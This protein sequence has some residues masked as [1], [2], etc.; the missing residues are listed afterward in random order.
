MNDAGKTFH[1]LIGIF[2]QAGI[3]F[4]ITGGLAA[5]SYGST[6]P[7]NDIDIDIHDADLERL[8]PDVRQYVTFGPARVRDAKW[9]LLLMTLEHHEQMIDIAGGDDAKIRDDASDRWIAEHT[10]FSD[11]ELRQIFGLVV[12]VISPQQLI[13][14]KVLLTGAHQLEDID[15]VLRFV[16]N[17]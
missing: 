9:D 13:A 15:A 3:P 17:R 4:V 7:L 8:R 12:P 2:R 14:Y 11:V 5:R 10:D 6:R 1:W 16:K